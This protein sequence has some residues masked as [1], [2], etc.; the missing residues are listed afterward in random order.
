MMIGVPAGSGR[1]GGRKEADI[2]GFKLEGDKLI[3]VHYEISS[4]YSRSKEVVKHV[5]NKF[6]E[7]RVKN[8]IEYIGRSVKEY[9]ERILNIINM[10]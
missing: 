1:G 9:L 5:L 2:V 8:I 10:R 4:K 3:I 6:T 7:D